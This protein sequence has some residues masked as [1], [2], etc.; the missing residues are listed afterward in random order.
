MEIREIILDRIAGILQEKYAEPVHDL[1]EESITA[2]L[3]FK[4]DPH[5]NELR[6][7]LERMRRGDY[8]RCIFC[9]CGIDEEV[10]RHSPTAHF[11]TRCANM[12]RYRTRAV[13]S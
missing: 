5:L 6:L 4:G 3:A 8:G 13:Q 10:L 12:L 2:Q 11:C 7:A 9:K 1:S